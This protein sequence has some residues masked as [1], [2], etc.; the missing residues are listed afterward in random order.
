MNKKETEEDRAMGEKVR[1]KECEKLS[2][3]MKL[4]DEGEGL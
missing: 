3:T 1:K 2:G 4:K